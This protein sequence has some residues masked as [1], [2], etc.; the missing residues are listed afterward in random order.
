MPVD[1]T[2]YA[3][4]I[5]QNAAFRPEARAALVNDLYAD[6]SL[7]ALATAEVA[8]ITEGQTR[9]MLM[10]RDHISRITHQ[11]LTWALAQ[12]DALIAAE[13]PAIIE[14]MEG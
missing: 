5:F 3:R 9:G 7:R 11:T 14:E 2:A 1:Q 13:P 12:V 8:R 4:T 10:D 6:P